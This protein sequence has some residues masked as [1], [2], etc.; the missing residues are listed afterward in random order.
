MKYPSNTF[1]ALTAKARLITKRLIYYLENGNYQRML[2]EFYERYI[3]RKLRLQSYR[4]A[5]K[6]EQKMTNNFKRI[7]GDD[8]E[9]AVCFGDFE[10]KRHMKFKEPTKGKG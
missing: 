6:S 2:L 1:L 8:K 10:Q 3:F 5:K 4:N 9:V 7:F